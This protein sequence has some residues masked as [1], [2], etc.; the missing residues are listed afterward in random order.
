MLPVFPAVIEYEVPSADTKVQAPQETVFRSVTTN[1]H[2][3]LHP[4]FARFRFACGTCPD[5]YVEPMDDPAPVVITPFT[6]NVV[7]SHVIRF[8]AAIPIENFVTPE[9]LPR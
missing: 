6:E 9:S 8:P 4:L 7:P 1:A 3:W 2:D 5:R